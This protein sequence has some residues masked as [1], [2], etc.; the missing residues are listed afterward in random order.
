MTYQTQKR[1][2]EI[3]KKV[4]NAILFPIRFALTPI[5]KKYW[6]Y[7]DRNYKTKRYTEKQIR[8][9]VQFAFDFWQD[10]HDEVYIINEDFCAINWHEDSIRMLTPYRFYEEIWAYGNGSLRRLKTKLGRM[11]HN[12]RNEFLEILWEKCP[13]TPMTEEEIKVEFDMYHYW[14]LKDK[15]I[16]KI[17]KTAE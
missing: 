8:N 7:K 14:K 3:Q 5:A 12:Q 2:S 6:A 15:T 1:I 16:Y 11:Y 9:A 13:V 4:V 17:S 10:R